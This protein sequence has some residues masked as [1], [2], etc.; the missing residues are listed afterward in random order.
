MNVSASN[1]YTVGKSPDQLKEDKAVQVFFRKKLQAT[2]AMKGTYDKDDIR[3]IRELNKF[4]EK[5]ENR[6]VAPALRLDKLVSRMDEEHQHPAKARY[7]KGAEPSF[8]RQARM[9]E[10][11]VTLRDEQVTAFISRHSL[12]AADVR[13][14][15]K[16]PGKAAAMPAYSERLQKLRAQKQVAEA[17]RNMAQLWEMAKKEKQRQTERRR[18]ARLRYEIDPVLS[19]VHQRMRVSLLST[20]E[21]KA[22]GI[23]FRPATLAQVID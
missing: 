3:E 19:G 18:D 11:S 12:K 14:K 17:E 7:A 2:K 6:A 9:A 21:R 5:Y 1:L 15:M 4:E 20:R 13:E 10:R 22:G 8:N 23:M 16:S